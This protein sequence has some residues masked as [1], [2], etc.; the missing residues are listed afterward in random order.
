MA[1]HKMKSSGLHVRGNAT[2]TMYGGKLSSPHVRN[3]NNDHV[4]VVANHPPR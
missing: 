3:E 2:H 1:I 4:E